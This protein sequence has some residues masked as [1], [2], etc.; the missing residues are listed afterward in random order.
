MK[1]CQGT[2]LHNNSTTISFT[3]INEFKILF[4]DPNDKNT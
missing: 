3:V 2:A 1:I 4:E